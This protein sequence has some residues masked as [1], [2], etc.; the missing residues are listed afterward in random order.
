MRS[1]VWIVSNNPMVSKKYPHAQLVDGDFLCVLTYLRD[2]VHAGD[3][4]ISHPLSGSVKPRETEYKSVLISKGQGGLDMKS[5]SLI[6]NAITTAKKFQPLSRDWKDPERI[7]R[8]FQTLDFSLLE[9]GIK[10]LNTSLYELVEDQDLD[11]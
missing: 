2:R 9:E 8:D 7:D 3:R 1:K 6:E 4:L 10:A 11:S 5:L